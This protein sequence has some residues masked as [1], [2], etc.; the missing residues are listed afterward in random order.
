LAAMQALLLRQAAHRAL[1]S[2]SEQL[3]R[4]LSETCPIGIFH[5]DAS[6]KVIYVNPEGARI[7]GREPRDL[8]GDDWVHSVHADDR[9]EVVS[10]WHA[11]AVAGTM[12][13]H[14]YRVVLRDGRTV[15]VRVR[16]QAVALAGGS[17]GGYVGSIED[18]GDQV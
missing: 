1:H 8:L 9:A 18:V 7:F 14:T 17:T 11:A 15:H 10:R 5:T 6:A 12:F 2:S 4:E 16:A 3:F 13:D